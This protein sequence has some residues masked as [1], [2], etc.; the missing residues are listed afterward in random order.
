MSEPVVPF[1][2]V[3]MFVGDAP[4]LFYLEI[5]FRCF[6]IYLYTLV[7][8]R[9]IGGRSVAQLSL[10]E[11]LLVIA[12]G[13]A[14][15]D[16]LFYPEVPILHALAVVTVIALINKAID[17]LIIR[18][19]RVKQVVDG[20]P[21]QVVRRG[22]IC[23]QAILDR[24]IGPAEMHSTLRAAGVRNLGEVEYAFFEPDGQLAIFRYDEKRPGLRIMPPPE[25]VP[26]DKVDPSDELGT[27]ACTTCGHAVAV[28]HPG[29]PCPECDHDGWTRAT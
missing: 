5:T 25:I 6:V 10:V 1:D 18:Y 29:G 14:V 3:R 11:F 27:L 9:W 26:F 2:L 19:R 24:K 28:P 22:A 12:L 17:I 7:V 4:P 21:V 20:Q 23:S 8:L 15:G 16:G 13:S